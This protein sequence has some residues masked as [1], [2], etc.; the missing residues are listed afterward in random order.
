MALLSLTCS[1]QSFTLSADGIK[2]MPVSTWIVGRG[3]ASAI[4]TWLPTYK[5]IMI[6]GDLSYPR[7]TH[8]YLSTE[9]YVATQS[10]TRPVLATESE[11]IPQVELKPSC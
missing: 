2:T 4:G 5:L 7:A 10:K 9:G 8:E 6:Q 11:T 1:S 3:Y